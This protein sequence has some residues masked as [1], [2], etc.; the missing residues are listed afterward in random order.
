MNIISESIGIKRRAERFS[1]DRGRVI[2]KFFKPGGRH[3]I[4]NVLERILT[5][6]EEQVVPEVDRV[7]HEFSHRHRRF[8]ESL[9]RHFQQIEEY[10]PKNHAL[11]EERKLLIGAYFTHEYSIAAAAMF[12]PSIVIAPDQSGLPDGFARFF[13]SFRATGEGQISSI[14]FRSGIMDDHCHIVFDQVSPYL[15]IPEIVVDEKFEK[16]LFHRKLVEMG[17]DNEVSLRMMDQLPDEFTLEQL[18]GVIAGLKGTRI[19]P[20]TAQKE[21]ISTVLWV[22]QSNYT[23]RFPS[24]NGISE[25]IIFPVSENE[26]RGIEDARFV[27]FIDDDGEVTYYATYTAYNGFRIL[28]QLIATKDFITF[29]VLTLNGDSAVDKGMAL[30]PRRIKGKYVMLGRQDGENN[31]IMYSDHLHFWYDAKIIQRP[32]Y[33]WQFI[34]IGNN[35]SPLET[36]EGWL[37]LIHGVGAMRK[38]CLGCVLLDLDD[39]SRIISQLEVPLISPNTDEREGYVPNVVYTCG[40]MIHQGEL[41]IPYAM[42]DSVSGI[43]TVS[44]SELL[45]Q[46]KQE[47]MAA[48]SLS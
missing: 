38:Y 4:E 39:P 40:A 19:L 16:K 48:H 14:E 26:S 37:V 43:A 33:P 25:R 44:I 7:F 24:E 41:I 30:F 29:K 27:R 35:G 31:Y 11:S 18:R 20:K 5:L 6:P 9:L 46:L 42:S 45:A 17:A 32:R 34:Q 13:M 15:E 10:L 36:A 47:S 23:V 28:P 2:T 1:P 22:A 21:A 12:N 8:R 3:R